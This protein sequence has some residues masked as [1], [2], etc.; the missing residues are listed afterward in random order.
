MEQHYW[1]ND[2]QHNHSTHLMQPLRFVIEQCQHRELPVQGG[3][4]KHGVVGRVQHRAV[5][6]HRVR[7][8]VKGGHTATDI[9]P[10]STVLPDGSVFHIEHVGCFV[11]IGDGDGQWPAVHQRRAVGFGTHHM[12][13]VGGHCFVVQE[14][15]VAQQLHLDDPGGGIDGEVLGR[16]RQG[17]LQRVAVRIHRDL[18]TCPGKIEM[19]SMSLHVLHMG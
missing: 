9:G 1:C 2:G 4:F 16:W 7:I 8:G 3:Q 18:L 11:G 10:R 6:Q 13:R 14:V 12:Q 19:F 17:P 5:R 15:V